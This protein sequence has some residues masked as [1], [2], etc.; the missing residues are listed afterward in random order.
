MDD[1]K[2]MDGKRMRQSYTWA[3]GYTNLLLA[4]YFLLTKDD[5]VLPALE[6][7]SVALAEGRDAAGLWGHRVANPEN[8]RGQLHGRLPGYAV[9]NQSSLSCFTSLLLAGKCGTN[10]LQ[11]RATRRKTWRCAR[12][13]RPASARSASPPIRFSTIFWNS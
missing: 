6:T 11:S 13:S 2:G 1:D 9:M 3:W 4:G 10:W 12:M 7:Y 8:N 5:Y